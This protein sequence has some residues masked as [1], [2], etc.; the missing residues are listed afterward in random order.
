MSAPTLFA[1]PIALQVCS[2]INKPNGQYVLGS[3]REAVMAFV[4]TLPVRKVCGCA[5]HLKSVRGVLR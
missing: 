5:L 1:I 4:G 2:D 3:S